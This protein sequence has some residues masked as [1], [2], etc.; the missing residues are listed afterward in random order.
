MLAALPQITLVVIAMIAMQRGST[1][2][3][4]LCFAIVIA[5]SVAISS[6]ALR[7]K[8]EGWQTVLIVFG[9]NPVLLIGAM[10]FAQP[11]VQA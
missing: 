3:L 4:M 2:V 8:F 7:L 11:S 9:I 6:Y 10:L 1:M 5:I